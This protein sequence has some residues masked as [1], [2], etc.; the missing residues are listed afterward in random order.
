VIYALIVQDPFRMGY[1]GIKTGLAASKGQA[2]P[3]FVDT[4]VNTITKANMNTPRSQELLSP[5][6]K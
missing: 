3:A 1:D 6:V 5:K 4:G 2:V